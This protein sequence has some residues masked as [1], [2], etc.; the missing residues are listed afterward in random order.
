MGGGTHRSP[1]KIWNT[2]YDDFDI[3]YGC[4]EYFDGKMK[5]ETFSVASSTPN[6]AT[7]A[8]AQVSKI[9]QENIPQYDLKKSSGLY[10]TKQNDWC[11]YE[12]HFDKKSKKASV[13]A[14]VY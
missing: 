8:L 7:N 2:N 14:T 3:S 10:W 12:W 11:K 6:L 9:V 5:F 1:I 4:S 13:D